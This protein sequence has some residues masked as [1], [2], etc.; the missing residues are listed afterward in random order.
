MIDSLVWFFSS[1][2][3]NWV[4]RFFTSDMICLRLISFPTG[5]RCSH[6]L[7]GFLPQSPSLVERFLSRFPFKV[8]IQGFHLRFLSKVSFKVPFQQIPCSAELASKER[9]NCNNV[10]FG[11]EVMWQ[12]S[13]TTSTHPV[14]LLPWRSVPPSLRHWVGGAR[15][16]FIYATE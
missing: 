5:L 2:S 1:V 13:T 3:Y 11:V 7:S 14:W 8:S 15:F 4:G 10:T 16:L 12:P 9:G 6:G